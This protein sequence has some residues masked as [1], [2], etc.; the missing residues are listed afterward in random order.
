M[1]RCL[2]ILVLMLSFCGASYASPRLMKSCMK[3]KKFSKTQCSCLVGQIKKNTNIKKAFKRAS[4]KFGNK[5][6]QKMMSELEAHWWT[7]SKYKNMP[8]SGKL[9]DEQS[10]MLVISMN[11]SMSCAS[12]K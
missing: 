5:F 11:A 6:N 9:N 10:M 4:K 3:D 12:T 1:F 7:S 2:S 8:K